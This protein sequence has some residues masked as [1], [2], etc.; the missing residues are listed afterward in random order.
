MQKKVQ[1]FVMLCFWSMTHTAFA[2]SNLKISGTVTDD[3]QKSVEGAVIYC[4]N[5]KDSSLVKTGLTEANGTFEIDALKKGNY[6]LS[7]AQANFQRF[8][9]KSIALD[10]TN[11]QLPTIA[12][13]TDNNTLSTVTV[14][15]K[16]PLIE[17]K[18]DRTILNVDALLSASGGTAW[19][20]LQ[21]T[22]GVVADE[23]SSIRLQGKSG[24]VIYIDD[25]PTYIAGDQLETY[26]KSLP[27]SALKQIEVMKNP[28]AKYDAA[29]NAG[30]INIKTKRSR[31]QGIN[32]N[33]ALAYTQGRYARSNN[34]LNLNFGTKNLNIFANYG[35]SF[36]NSFQDLYIN[37]YYKNTDGSAK[38]TFK[39]NSYIVKKFNPNT[40]KLGLDYSLNAKTTIGFVS[41]GIINPSNENNQ[42]SS[43][44]GNASDILTQ[45]V[46]ADNNS[47]KNFLNGSVNA[48]FRHDF[49]PDHSMTI[50]ADYVAYQSSN[51]QIF[52]NYGYNMLGGLNF[53]D[54]LNGQQP[55][56]IAIYALKFDHTRT[57]KHEIKLE[58]G[59]KMSYTNTDNEAIYE[60]T[61]SGIT[62][63]D[64]DL[65]NRFLYKENIAAAYINYSQ[66]IKRW[67]IQAGFR[68]EL[69]L[70]NGKQLG[71][72]KVDASD[73]NRNYISPFPT[74][75]VSYRLDS[76]GAQS[77]QFSYG[78]RIERPFFQDL[79]PFI[80][81]LD[82]FTFYTGNPLLKPTFADNY[83]LTY[84]VAGVATSLG[85]SYTNDGIFET[86]EI[87]PDGMYYSRP[88]NIGVS[89]S[90][91]LGVETAQP[92]T[93]WWTITAS[94]EGGYNVYRSALY[95]E[96]LNSKGFYGVFNINNSF[97]LGKGWTAELSGDYQTAFVYAQ[98]ILAE[99][100]GLNAA[101]QKKILNGKGTLRLSVHDFLYS[102][103]FDGIINNLAN[104]TA[105]WNSR[106]D[107][108]SV[109]LSFSYAFGKNLSKVKRHTGNGSEAERGRV[110]S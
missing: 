20:V 44:V 5:A 43:R 68:G 25:K 42:N 101:V 107:T 40:L 7:V 90:L 39:Q 71:N 67:D 94:A 60:R 8:W 46:V 17:R 109:N 73:F 4:L 52:K 18:A 65:S 31:L 47:A 11:V 50:D 97:P 33:V 84:N 103:R 69:T 66:T 19:D 51:D 81:P 87:Q 96:T 22:P 14:A 30:I 100:G 2:Q 28:P 64:Y 74:L 99:R 95:T 80:S 54:R 63:P 45:T 106:L 29:G 48:N 72:A 57:L 98:L 49:S 12:L 92:I 82:K 88:N 77:L 83:S 70:M 36:H 55:S 6:I 108:R 59:V 35:L 78:K 93:K 15:A 79:N 85:Y 37:R 58:S 89:E 91:T 34:S 76:A 16:L 32:G 26:L 27:A 24:V 1:I 41:S 105:D 102:K 110:K 62:T 56:N 86:L 23:G 53:E 9:T 61:A 38:S 21:K 75:F 3:A 10:A 13:Q 104:T